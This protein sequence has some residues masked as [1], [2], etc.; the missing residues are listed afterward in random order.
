MGITKNNKMEVDYR[1]QGRYGSY[2][3]KENLITF[4]SKV[5]RDLFNKFDIIR[6]LKRKSRRECIEDFF[7]HIVDTHSSSKGIF[8]YMETD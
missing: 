4:Q 5:D 2:S 3:D 6:K 1:H 8:Q 7:N